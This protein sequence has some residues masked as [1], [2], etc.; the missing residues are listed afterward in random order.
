MNTTIHGHLIDLG[1]VVLLNVSQDP[2]VIIFHKVD[3]HTLTAIAPGPTNPERSKVMLAIF[4]I[5]TWRQFLPSPGLQGLPCKTHRSK[6]IDGDP[7]TKRFC[8]NTHVAGQFD[9]SWLGVKKHGMECQNISPMDVELSVVGQVI[10]DD[11]RNLGN[12]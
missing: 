6:A 3:G 2:D 10:V 1:G 11:Q 12:V 5:Q 7:R 9:E 4:S 8:S